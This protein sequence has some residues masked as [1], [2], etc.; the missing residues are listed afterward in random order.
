MHGAGK[1][2]APKG[3][4]IPGDVRDMAE[5]SDMQKIWDNSETGLLKGSASSDSSSKPSEEDGVSVDDFLSTYA[6][7]LA[8]IATGDSRCLYVR[9]AS[10]FWADASNGNSAATSAIQLMVRQMVTKPGQWG[11]RRT[12]DL[13]T[14]LFVVCE[15][16]GRFGVS[17]A[18]IEQCDREPIFPL[19]AGGAI[20][21]RTLDILTPEEIT[22]HWML[23][24]GTVGLDY[25]PELLDAG[26]GHPGTR[27]AL[28]Y[29]P[30][31]DNPQ[32]VL[33]RRIAYMLLEP[34][35]AVDVIIMPQS[36]A[37]KTTFLPVGQ[38]GPAGTGGHRR[39]CPSHE[40]AGAEVHR[41][42][43]ASGQT[44][45][46]IPRRVRQG[47]ETSGLRLTERADR[48][49]PD[50][51]AEGQ[52]QL[53]NPA[54]WKHLADGRGRSQHRGRGREGGKG[55]AG[56]STGRTSRQCPPS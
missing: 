41:L 14:A 26:D 31:P 13:R 23:D 12:D 48:R 27:V 44:A 47:G 21:A 5:P 9:C 24:H 29:E 6:D 46:A 22:P 35:K 50:H 42:A 28:H 37:G 49:F 36:D 17:M 19:K 30:D 45:T 8:V 20:D 18:S 51:R 43:A 25:R 2:E 33:I 15:D 34:R 1:D 55:W 52:G 54:G 3:E 53:R 4:S 32:H 39:R 16:P 7:R 10:G 11:Q 38:Y 40:P 56:P